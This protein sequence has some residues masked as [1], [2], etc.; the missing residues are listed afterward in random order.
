MVKTRKFNGKTY[1][2]QTSWGSKKR[3]QP[4]A[5]RIRKNGGLARVIKGKSKIGQTVYRVY[6][7]KTN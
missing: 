6:A 4:Q 3:A 1:R 5:N 2:L 7:K